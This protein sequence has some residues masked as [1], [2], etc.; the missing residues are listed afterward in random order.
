MKTFSAIVLIVGLAFAGFCGTTNET[1]NAAQTQPEQLFNRTYKV[2]VDDE[3]FANNL[4]HLAGVKEGEDNLQMLLRFFK[5]NGVKIES[6]ATFFW[7][8]IGGLFVHTTL[9]DQ[10][11]IEKLVLAIQNNV[12]PSAVR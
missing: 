10:N 3:A 4:K 7:A 5:Q 6:L 2:S 11:K 1:N 12:Q 9:A 8:H